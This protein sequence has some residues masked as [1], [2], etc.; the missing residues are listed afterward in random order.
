[1]HLA[2]D[3]T[4][5]DTMS[6]LSADGF[7][8][9]PNFFTHEDMRDIWSDLDGLTD[10]FCEGVGCTSTPCDG[11]ER[12]RRLVAIVKAKPEIQSSLYDRLQ[13]MPSL[14]SIPSHPKVVQLARAALRSERLGVW[15]RVQLRFDGQSDQKN[16]IAWHHD[17]LYNGGTEHSYTFWMPLVS[18]TKRMGMLLFAERSHVRDDIQFVRTD[19]GRRFDYDLDE[20]LLR[21][22][23]I[24][25]HDSYQAG[26]LVLF[27][28]KCIHSGQINSEPDR[29]RLTVL[30]R[31]QDVG[32][33][34]IFKH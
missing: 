10:A 13:A 17:Y 24:L 8:Y 28:S 3:K 22:F 21:Q 5:S 15:P 30:F 29:A 16:L 31:M 6:R 32:T 18:I 25:S 33:L 23:N 11:Q 14:L 4:D 2:V 34:E 9:L 27:H 1:M 7:L 26:D 12:D 19:V 20:N